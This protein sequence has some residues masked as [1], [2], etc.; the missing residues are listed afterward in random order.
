[1]FNIP[2]SADAFNVLQAQPDSRDFNGILVPA[3]QGTGIIS[4]CAVTAQAAPNMT[5]AVASGSIAITGTSVAV[6]GGN[7]TITTANA[8]NPRFD[9]ICVDNAGVKSAV[10]GTPNA[11]PVF[12]DPAGKVVL[13]AVLVPAAAGSI[14]NQMITDKRVGTLIIASTSLPGYPSDVRKQLNGD[15]SW[16]YPVIINSTK[17]TNY[18][19]VLTDAN[20]VIEMNV[21]GTL[22]VPPNSAVAFPLGTTVEIAQLAGGQS[23]IAAGAG[24]TLRAYNN[25]LRLA[26]QYAMCSIIKRGTDDWWVAGNLVP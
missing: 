13:A 8:S 21:A 3:F 17:A 14:T 24:V 23:N 4:G 11:A 25:N 19:L 5:V 1:L 10:A 16:S 9:L 7:V 12:P 22:T 6:T 18:T 2:N 26:G 20:T 15:G